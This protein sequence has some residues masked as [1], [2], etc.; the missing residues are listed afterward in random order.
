MS[1]SSTILLFVGGH[2]GCKV[3]TRNRTSLSTGTSADIILK[4]GPREGCII[5]KP[6]FSS[7][8]NCVTINYLGQF[9]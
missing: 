9:G 4:S 8:Q 7:P 1:L 3:F 6:I 2:R 5:K